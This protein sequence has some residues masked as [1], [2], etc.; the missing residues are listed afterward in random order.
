ME[1]EQVDQ[2]VGEGVQ[3]QAKRVGQEAMTAEPVGTEAVLELLNAV[4][5][6]SALVVEA[7]DLGTAARAVGDQET[8]IGT[9][10]GMLGFGDDAA[11]SRPGAGAM[12]EAGEGALG[13][14]GATI[15]ASPATLQ[16]GGATT[17][18]DIGGNAN[19]VV[20]AEEL[21]ELIKQRYGKTGIGTQADGDSGKLTQQTTQ[22]AQEQGTMRA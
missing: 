2:V 6:F 3:E 14:M 11:Q 16:S 5:A 12:A 15:A 18:H 22:D 21:A 4:L 17:K 1:A 19:G 20:N 9:R 7:K 10:G 8:K 13:E